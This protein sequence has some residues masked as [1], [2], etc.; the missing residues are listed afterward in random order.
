MSLQTVRET[1]SIILFGLRKNCLISGRSLLFYQSTGRVIKLTVI[2]MGCHVY[3]LYTILSNIILS[4]LNPYIFEVTGDHQRGFWRNRS[5]TDQ[6]FCIHQTLE[7][8]WEYNETL[9][10]VFIDL[11]EAYDLVR[12]EVLYSI[13]VEFGV[14]RLEPQNKT[15]VCNNWQMC[16]LVFSLITSRHVSAST[17]GHLQVISVT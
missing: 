5:T 17:C 6:I 13:F 2:I 16:L 7:K 15:L 1:N 12:K 8:K 9:R 3:Q 4:R 10:Q 11:K 14:L